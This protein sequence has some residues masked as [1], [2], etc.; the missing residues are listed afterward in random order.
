MAEKESIEILADRVEKIACANCKHHLDISSLPLFTLFNC[1]ECHAQQM[2]PGKLGNFLLLEELGRGGMG[3][4]YRGQD[5][6]LGRPVAIKV[7]HKSLGDDQQFLETFLREARAAAAINHRNVVQI[8]SFGREKGQP[9]LVMEL[10]DGGRLDAYI[11]SSQPLTEAQAVDVCLD[12]SEGLKAAHDAGLMHGDVKPA[13]ILFDQKGVAKVADFGLAGFIQQQKAGS[14]DIWGTP[15]YIAPEKARRQKVDQRA[16]I[17]SLGATMF[18]AMT[19]RPPFDGDTPTHV[20]L[21]RLQLPPPD[22]S[23]ARTDLHPETVRIINRMLAA[24]P[25]VRYPSYASLIS[26]LQEAKAKLTGAAG[27]KTGSGR[28]AAKSKLWIYL[29]AGAGAVLLIAAIVLFAAKSKPPPP[30]PAPLPA[31]AAPP[32]VAPPAVAPAA[33][34]I[35]VSTDPVNPFNAEEDRLIV[36]ALKPLVLGDTTKVVDRL[37]LLR[38]NVCTNKVQQYWLQLFQALAYQFDGRQSEFEKTLKALPAPPP[39]T[40][41]VKD[42]ATRI[43]LAA[44]QFLLKKTEKGELLN[45]NGQAPA[46]CKVF[47]DFIEGWR[48][49]T[50][51]L[52]RAN[53]HE[54]FR[55]YKPTAANDPKWPFAFQPLTEAWLIQVEKFAGVQQRLTMLIRNQKFAEARTFLKKFA[56]KCVPIQYNVTETALRNLE[57]KEKEAGASNQAGDTPATPPKPAT[58]APQ[59]PA[60]APTPVAPKPEPAVPPPPALKA[61]FASSETKTEP[62]RLTID[63]NLQ[64]RWVSQL[65]DNQWLAVDLGNNR[66]VTGV[67]LNWDAAYAVDYKIQ[68]SRD[69]AFWSDVLRVANSTGGREIKNFKPIEGRYVRIYC[70]IR[71]YKQPNIALFEVQVLVDGQKAPLPPSS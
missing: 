30:P 13:N 67:V 49:W 58:P 27:S 64:T 35:N 47:V 2:V 11:T 55:A 23:T 52:M 68:V 43:P 45:V 38:I 46:W 71:N 18:H 8:F 54:K 32:V 60:P 20:V 48:I 36:E 25:A 29:A 7:M 16:D 10:V 14:R 57:K 39:P 24:D 44:A 62:A 40:T 1:P 4:V 34:N 66:K 61:A 41:D 12:V 69:R 31:V 70:L 19:I 50:T 53:A 21:A 22:I 28:N 15:F 17:Y 56:T 9:Y 33:T 37:E 42:E 5:L 6:A 3:V 63:G 59:K 51:G 26:D 65:R